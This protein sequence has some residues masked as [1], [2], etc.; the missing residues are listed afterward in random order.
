MDDIESFVCDSNAYVSI[1]ASQ[2]NGIDF[3]K[4][5]LPV[6]ANVCHPQEGCDKKQ[7]KQ[8]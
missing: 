1:N 8:F 6:S 5:V 7:Y 4:T 2:H 3:I